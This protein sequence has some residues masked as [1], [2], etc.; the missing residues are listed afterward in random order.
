VS[1]E[2]VGQI[3]VRAFE[4][5]QRAAMSHIAGPEG[6]SARSAGAGAEVALAF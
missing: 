6:P 1:P 4:K 3:E 5:V 2:R